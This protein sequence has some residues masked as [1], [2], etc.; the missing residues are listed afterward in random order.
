MQAA[1]LIS[2][3]KGRL[4]GLLRKTGHAAVREHLQQDEESGKRGYKPLELALISEAL[5]ISVQLLLADDEARRPRES[6]LARVHPEA[7]PATEQALA[8][9]RQMLELD[10]LLIEQGFSAPPVVH[11]PRPSSGQPYHQGELLA[12]RLRSKSGLAD[13]D[14]PTD[15]S[16][17]AADV[18]DKFNADV[19]IEPLER[20]LDGLA[21]SRPGY[22]LIMVSSSIPAHRQRY[23][24]AH[25]LGHLMAGDQGDIIDENINYSRTTAETRANAFAA[26]RPGGMPSG[27][28]LPHGS[29]CARAGR[30]RSGRVHADEFRSCRPD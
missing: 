9:V 19:A 24:I 20:G 12:Q 21:I 27:G 8:R 30:R 25:E 22:R 15:V 4:D 3:I 16:Q 17:L 10:E 6:V 7:N 23:T 2:D 13:A 1:R 29:H 28:C 18:E 14:L 5:G 11:L 26:A